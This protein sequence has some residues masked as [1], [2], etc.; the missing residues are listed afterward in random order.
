[1]SRTLAPILLAALLAGCGD[2]PPPQEKKA[3]EGRAETK[4]IRNTEAVGYS[5][6]A[7]A[8]KVD[9]ALDK[10]D[11]ATR[12]KQEEAERQSGD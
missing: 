12:K 8:D 11:E 5:G 3:P 2:E 9:T 10:N 4:G 6:Q 1:M 7:I